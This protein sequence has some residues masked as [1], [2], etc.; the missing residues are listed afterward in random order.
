MLNPKGEA[1]YFSRSVIPYLRNFPQD[2]WLEKNVFYKHIGIYAYKRS[3]LAKLALLEASPLEQQESLEQLRWL[4]NGYKIS[5]ALTQIENQAID[6]P[7][8]LE[9]LLKNIE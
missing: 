8:D 7:E 4:E 1:I 5:T 2:Q 6:T 3:I 9:R